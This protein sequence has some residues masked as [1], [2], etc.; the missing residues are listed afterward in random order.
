MKKFKGGK[1][2]TLLELLIVVVI[3]AIL[4]GLALPQYIRTVGRARESEG[5]QNLGILRSALSRYYAEWGEVATDWTGLDITDPNAVTTGLFDYTVS[6][7]TGG[8]DY[9]LDA[10]PRGT[11]A[12]CRTLT[13]TMDGERSEQ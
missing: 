8:Y 13:I 1:G 2:F 4:A 5:W 7:G 11:C 3:L 9:T 10:T 6:A 12:G